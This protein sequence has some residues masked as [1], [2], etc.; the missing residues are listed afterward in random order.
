MAALGFL[1]HCRTPAAQIGPRAR[2]AEEAGFDEAWVVDDLT[3]AGGLASAALAL[4]ATQDLKI[5]LGI[6]PAVARSPAFAAMDVATLAG[7]HPGRLR[8]GIGHGIGPWMAQIGA[9]VESPLAA[10]EEVTATVRELLAGERVTRHGRHV[11][12]DDVALDQP[13]EVAPPIL[14]GATGPRSIAAATR[15]A[16]GLIL[17][18]GCPPAFVATVRER[19][20]AD[21][22]RPI[23][24]VY[25]LLSLAEDPDAARDVLRP[26]IAGQ[27]A[28]RNAPRLLGPAGLAEPV[29]EFL[30][31]VP[32]EERA[33]KLPAEWIDALAVVGDPDGAAAAVAAYAE[34]GADAVVLSPPDPAA[35][36]AQLAAAARHL[37]PRVRA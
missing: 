18:D 33:A 16:D 15:V 11:Q 35:G 23:L 30:E 4:G 24:V 17:P 19:L 34:A 2:A 7:A 1:I 27:I 13:P 26:I 28:G 36:E 21:G 8:V 10:L 9:A 29:A 31:R 37:V 25:A 5:G 22:P 6:L 20:D 32:A 3:Y 12:H 14:V